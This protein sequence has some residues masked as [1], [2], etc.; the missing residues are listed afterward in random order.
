MSKTINFGYTD[1]PIPGVTSLDFSRG[2]INFGADFR[3]KSDKKDELILTNLT[4]PIDRPERF[5]IA[6][7]LI[8]SIYNGSGIS[9]GN[10]A[11]SL[12]GVNLLI[13]LTEVASITDS[14]DASYRVDVPISIHCVV[15][16]PAVEELTEAHI[17]AALGRLVSGFYETGSTATTRI[18]ALVR[19]SLE[20]TDI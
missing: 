4:S 14:A 10:Q 15:K 9:E 12:R 5:R 19:G 3:V 20:P 2:L 17:Q 11:P 7:S 6:W 16:V 18:K 1:T 8:D 13:Q